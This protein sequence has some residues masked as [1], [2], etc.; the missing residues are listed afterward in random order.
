MGRGR[1]TDR[2]TDGLRD[3]HTDG[4]WEKFK[5][6]GGHLPFGPHRRP[7]RKCLSVYQNW[8][9]ASHFVAFGGG[10]SLSMSSLGFVIVDP[11][12]VGNTGR[13]NPTRRHPVGEPLP[14]HP[15]PGSSHLALAAHSKQ[16]SGVQ[17]KA[18]ESATCRPPEFTALGGKERNFWVE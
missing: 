9:P 2:K 17:R 5:L 10:A 4:T 3:R 12:T 16:P 11:A 13:C 8:D 6:T 18:G 1:K 14:P 15:P 7:G